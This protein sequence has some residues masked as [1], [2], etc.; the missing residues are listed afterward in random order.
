[1]AIE[2]NTGLSGAGSSS[3]GAAKS[4]EFTGSGNFTMQSA[5]KFVRVILLGAGGGGG[6]GGTSGA[7]V[8]CSGGAGGGGAGKREL[9]LTRAEVLAA[10][11]TGVV[12]IGIAAGGTAGASVTNAGA[13]ACD[14]QAACGRVA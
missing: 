5:T 12:P 14:S 8:V 10:Y 2:A 4:T 11:P 13:D 9:V 3:A 6:S 7:G 1:M